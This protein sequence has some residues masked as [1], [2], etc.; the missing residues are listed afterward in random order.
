MYFVFEHFEYCENDSLVTKILLRYCLRMALVSTKW[1]NLA[2]H[3]FSLQHRFVKFILVFLHKLTLNISNH[4]LTFNISKM[5]Y[6]VKNGH[7][8][9]VKLLL[10]NGA[11]VNKADNIG[12]TPIFVAARV[13]HLCFTLCFSP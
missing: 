11:D 1:I 10:A 6:D 12:A 2:K 13:F 9:V 4:K 5:I 8:D 3:L 7:T